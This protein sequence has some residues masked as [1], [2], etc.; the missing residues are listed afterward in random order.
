M[1]GY[2]RTAGVFGTYLCQSIDR[3]LACLDGLDATASRWRP[4]APEANSLHTLALHTL[5]NAEENVLEVLAGQQ[6]GR[7]RDAEFADDATTPDS[8]RARW[9]DLRPRLEAALA[10]LPDAD[11]AHVQTHPRRAGLTG[12]EVLITTTRHAAEHAG[13]AELT[14]D[15]LR[16]SQTTWRP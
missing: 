13:Q 5:G 8:I 3:L 14:R 7:D 10:A 9:A 15:L 6:V 12:L 4:P 2:M 16:A 1:L 11:L